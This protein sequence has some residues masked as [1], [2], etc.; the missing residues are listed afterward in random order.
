MRE[1]TS[2]VHSVCL[3]QTTGTLR[4]ACFPPASITYFMHARAL[5]HIASFG[6]G[7]RCFIRRPSSRGQPT[8]GPDTWP[9][10]CGFFFFKLDVACVTANTM[11]PA[12]FNLLPLDFEGLDT[13]LLE[14]LCLES[15]S[16]GAPSPVVSSPVPEPFAAA[17]AP[18][19]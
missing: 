8:Y 4:G 6:A 2:N 1:P 14:E 18:T 19:G 3:S 5:I 16:F 15:V 12:F 13:L 7:F 11:P 17:G 9:Y 10:H